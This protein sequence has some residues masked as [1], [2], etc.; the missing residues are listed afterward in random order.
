MVAPVTC[1]SVT[2]L[3]APLKVPEPVT[4]RAWVP[5]TV[6]V[7]STEEPLKLSSAPS[8]TPLL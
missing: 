8:V 5:P 4:V 1:K 2:P 7:K 6:L 3:T